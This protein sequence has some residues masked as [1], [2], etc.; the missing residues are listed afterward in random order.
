MLGAR[1]DPLLS[2]EEI[3]IAP[4]AV[5]GRLRACPSCLMVFAGETLLYLVTLFALQPTSRPRSEC[6][7]GDASP[8]LPPSARSFSLLVSSRAREG[9]AGSMSIQGEFARYCSITR[10][11]TTRRLTLALSASQPSTTR[12]CIA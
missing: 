1:A 12:P 9:G 8:F 10:A 7:R 6:E 5:V 3:E 4:G 2:A 11:P